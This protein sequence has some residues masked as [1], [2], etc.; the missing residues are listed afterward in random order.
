MRREIVCL[1][2]YGV[3]GP[4]FRVIC[5]ALFKFMEESFEVGLNRETGKSH[6]K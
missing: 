6:N 2:A 4:V 3:G 1:C 5:G